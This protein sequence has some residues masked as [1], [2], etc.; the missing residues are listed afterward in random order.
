MLV[1]LQNFKNTHSNTKKNKNFTL[2]L[3][4][5]ASTP[6]PNTHLRSC[7]LLGIQLYISPNS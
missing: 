6:P 5:A 7:N 1:R 4:Q 2:N 3:S